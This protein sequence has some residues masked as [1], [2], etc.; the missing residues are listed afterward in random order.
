MTQ[1]PLSATAYNY[2]LSLCTQIRVLDCSSY[3][4]SDCHFW[5]IVK[6][7]SI[8]PSIVP[9]LTLLQTLVFPR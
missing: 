4:S 5:P 6:I 1:K 3:S 8:Q 2:L 7:E 9:S